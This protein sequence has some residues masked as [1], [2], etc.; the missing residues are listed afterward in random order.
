MWNKN[1]P[2]CPKVR[3]THINYKVWNFF[4]KH[5]DLTIITIQLQNIGQIE[6]FDSTDKTTFVI[7][8]RDAEKI[9]NKSARDLTKKQTR[10]TTYWN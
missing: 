7:F 5:I 2:A 8:D 10:G 3:G 1:K 6:V 4:Y 9:L